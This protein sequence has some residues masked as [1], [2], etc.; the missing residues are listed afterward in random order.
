MNSK[1]LDHKLAQQ[2]QLAPSLIPKIRLC[3]QLVT[4]V[5]TGMNAAPAIF[6]MKAGLGSNQPWKAEAIANAQIT[7]NTQWFV[8]MAVD[9]P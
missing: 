2:R 5:A 4:S 7:F 1:A 8:G 6:E 3:G 9:G